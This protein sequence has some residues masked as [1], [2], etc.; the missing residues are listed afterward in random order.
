MASQA[1]FTLLCEIGGSTLCIELPATSPDDH[2]KL[3]RK[4]S[5][6]FC[7]FLEEL[8]PE[9]EALAGMVEKGIAGLCQ[10]TDKI[11]VDKRQSEALCNA[12][13]KDTD[14]LE[15]EVRSQVL[16]K[17]R[18]AF[19]V[20]K[21]VDHESI[22]CERSHDGNLPQLRKSRRLWPR[23]VQIL[24]EKDP[25]LQFLL[26]AARDAVDADEH[27]QEQGA[28]S[29]MPSRCDG[30]TRRP[31]KLRPIPESFA[32]DQEQEQEQGAHSVVPS[33]CDGATRRPLKLRPIPESFAHDQE[34]EDL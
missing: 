34:Q 19:R 1:N 13:T 6:A 23:D 17:R 14:M 28:H 10:L 12:P 20:E 18:V 26:Q 16:P 4:V 11:E 33:R 3:L 27:E 32:H 9:D 31:L 30:A 2:F 15:A 8:D 5:D 25:A 21:D 29:S 7:D 22:S 24:A